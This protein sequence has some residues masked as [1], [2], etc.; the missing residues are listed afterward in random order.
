MQK[1]LENNL[2]IV[3]SSIELACD[4]SGINSKDILLI[5][6][7]KRKSL[8]HIKSVIKIGVTNFGE[9][10]SQELQEKSEEL[11]LEN[12]FWHFIGPIQSN[13]IKIIAK[14]AH[15]VHSLDRESVVVKLNDQ[16]GVLNKTINGLIQINISNESSKSGIA[17]AEMENFAKLVENSKSI[18]LKGIMV[19]PKLTDDIEETK[20]MM[21]LSKDLHDKLVKLYPHASYLSMGT[22][23]DFQM[24]IE[25]GSNMLR[26]GD[27]IFG[28]RL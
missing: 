18:N 16:C 27:L 4:S 7:S 23:S 12:I 14:H 20:S 6:V 8:D 13:K 19:L 21:R 10:Y 11:A 22:T 28:K 3:N 24:A 5:A 2:E 9:N 26:I 25:C 17:P 15:W 1:E